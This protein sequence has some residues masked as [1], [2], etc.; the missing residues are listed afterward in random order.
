[1]A[2]INAHK[3]GPGHLTFGEAGSAK[4]F[5]IALT[6]AEVVPDAKD[7]EVFEVLSGDE[8]VDE[9]E[10]TWTLQGSVFQSYD[11]DSLI[12]WC[13][14][15]SG[16]NLPFT[17]VPVDGQALQAKGTALIRSIRLGGD[18]KVRNKSDFKFQ[19]TNVVISAD[20]VVVP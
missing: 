1:M 19:A 3:L 11:A 20:A 15:N 17:F 12:L 5:G 2:A 18:V 13:N 6:A 7:A 16:S 8:V 10:E 4:E 14:Q 9:G